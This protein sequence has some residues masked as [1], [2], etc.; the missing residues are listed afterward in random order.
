MP[1]VGFD[2]A[3][4]PIERP[5]EM[6]AFYK[7]LGFAIVGE[8]EWRDGKR[9]GFAIQFGESKINAHPPAV[10][11]NPSFTLRGP[12]ALPGCGDFCF[13]WA[14]GLEA[15][16]HT[17]AAAGAVIEQGPVPR[18]GGRGGGHARG[19]SIYTRDPDRNLL[20]FIV[21]DQAYSGRDALSRAA[22]VPGAAL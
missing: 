9:G 1:V 2:H 6:I 13:V 7:R 12:T 19:T 5:E 4:I 14:G 8:Q 11:S 10:W 18:E 17:L 3:A 15:L 20:E 21:Y 22:L 16:Q